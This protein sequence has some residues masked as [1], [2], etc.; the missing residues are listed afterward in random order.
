MKMLLGITNL[1]TNKRV[2]AFWLRFFLLLLSASGE[3]RQALFLF[4][5]VQTNLLL[6]QNL[7]VIIMTK[8]QRLLEQLKQLSTFSYDIALGQYNLLKNTN[9]SKQAFADFEDDLKGAIAMFK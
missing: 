2:S 4:A 6:Y 9:A 7:G 8:I 1:W 3:A 5:Q